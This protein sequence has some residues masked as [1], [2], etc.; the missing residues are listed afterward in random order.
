MLPNSCSALL[1][2]SGFLARRLHGAQSP[3]DG[4]EA[5][6]AIGGIE[7][8]PERLAQLVGLLRPLALQRP[9]DVRPDLV[10]RAPPLH[11]P[12]DRRLDADADW[13]AG[14]LG[15][16]VPDRSILVGQVPPVFTDHRLIP[17]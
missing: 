4:V 15:P 2:V 8:Q 17:S 11:Q 7:E 14:P 9:V 1:V 10:L 13:L 6:G 3:H 16:G 5:A 12:E